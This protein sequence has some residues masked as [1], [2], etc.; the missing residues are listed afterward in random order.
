MNVRVTVLHMGWGNVILT[1]PKD[2]V[3]R[4]YK[5]RHGFGSH[6]FAVLCNRVND[7]EVQN[8]SSW[9]S[10]GLRVP[11]GFCALLPARMWI[12]SPPPPPHTEFD[13]QADVLLQWSDTGA[14]TLCLCSSSALWDLETFW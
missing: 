10:A 2:T 12:P 5:S 8:T 7:P 13:P 6:L 9:S 11:Q 4:I 1:G 3:H 14:D